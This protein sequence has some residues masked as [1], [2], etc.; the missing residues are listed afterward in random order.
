METISK[1]TH[2]TQLVYAINRGCLKKSSRA[3]PN[4][5]YLFLYGAGHGLMKKIYGDEDEDGDSAIGAY[6][7]NLCQ[8]RK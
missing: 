4:S 1:K 5:L 2:I 6:I 7:S 3:D 8:L